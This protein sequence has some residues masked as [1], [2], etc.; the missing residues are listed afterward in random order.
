MSLGEEARL[1]IPSS[2]GYGAAGAGASIPPNADLVFV[3]ELLTIN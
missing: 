1:K 3:V 2:M